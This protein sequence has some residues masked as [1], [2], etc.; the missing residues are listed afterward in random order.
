MEKVK[1]NG[2]YYIAEI[3]C[4]HCG[5]FE[6]AKMM[7]YIAKYICKVDAVKFQKRTIK[8]CLTEEE[9]NRPHPVPQNSYGK[10]YGEH[11]SYL[12][13]SKYKHMKLKEYCD[14]IQIDY[15]CSVWDI[16]AAKEIISIRP[17]FVKIPSACN[18]NIELL[19]FIVRNYDGPIHLS[20]GMLHKQETHELI[21][22]I[23]K[24]GYSKRIV[25]YHCVSG[26]PIKT[27]D[28]CLLEIM[29]L[30]KEK[31]T[32]RGI[33]FS[34]HHKGI[35]ID[36]GAIALG[37]Q[38]IERHYTLNHHLKGTDHIASLEPD[39]FSLLV[40][41]GEEKTKGYIGY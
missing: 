8:A 2:L 35:N 31:E 25:L 26:Y 28:V 9:Y 41:N 10:S 20:L 12:E 37:A 14:E 13:F 23:K 5:N 11:R 22:Y 34:G 32:F 7:I 33:G 29:S 4:N 36:L 30:M 38:Y 3:G 6:L 39:E 18:N 15:G 19:E 17:A 21:E 40:S 1:K 16:Q 24:R 27:E